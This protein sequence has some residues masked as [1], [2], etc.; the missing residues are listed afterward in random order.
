MHWFIDVDSDVDF[1]KIAVETTNFTG[2]DLKA[3]VFNAQLNAKKDCV[4]LQSAF[5]FEF[6][7]KLIMI[8]TSLCL[9]C[10]I[11]TD[12]PFSANHVSDNAQQNDETNSKDLNNF[13]VCLRFYYFGITVTISIRNK[14]YIEFNEIFIKYLKVQY[15]L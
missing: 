1:D 2:A 6:N 11:L 14:R 15:R 4:F 9:K 7:L 5:A 12:Y 10:A 13:E 3:L 8:L